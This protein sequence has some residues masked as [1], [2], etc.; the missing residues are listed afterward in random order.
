[1]NQPESLA[2]LPDQPGDDSPVTAGP[3]RVA[4]VADL[5]DI[6]VLE[7]SGFDV[8]RWSDQAWAQELADPAHHHVAVVSDLSGVIALQRVGETA[9]LLRVVVRPQARRHGLGR[10]LVRHG[11]AWARTQGAS[12]VFLEVSET[13]TG[14][15]RL[16]QRAG[17][18][19]VARRRDY[20]GPGQTAVVCRWASAADQAD[21]RS[22]DV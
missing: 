14:A 16:Y 20:Y 6:M 7:R 3:I 18:E 11:L 5:A 13:N 12:E 19:P 22:D 1:M 9:E 17:F 15:L 10:R 21:T 2:P 4:T 8:G